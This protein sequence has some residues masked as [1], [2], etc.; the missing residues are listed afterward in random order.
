MLFYIAHAWSEDLWKLQLL[1]EVSQKTYL[2]IIHFGN[3]QG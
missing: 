3:D 2:T 1:I